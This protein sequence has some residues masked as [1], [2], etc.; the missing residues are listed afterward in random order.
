MNAVPSASEDRGPGDLPAEAYARMAAVLRVG[1]LAAVALLAAS[2]AALLVRSAGSAAGA[3]VSD[4]PLTRYLDVRGLA[5]GLAAGT[6]EA[7]L[8]LGALV[9]IATPVVRV[10]TGTYSFFRHGEVR[11]GGLTATVLAL[12]LIGLLVVGPLVR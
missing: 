1:L 6:P 12:L 7:Y 8:T 5:H 11:M 4:N 9:L 2:L 3:W 10:V